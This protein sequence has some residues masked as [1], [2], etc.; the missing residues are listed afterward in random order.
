MWIMQNINSSSLCLNLAHAFHEYEPGSF[1]SVV[2]R[3]YTEN[4]VSI[5]GRG[6]HIFLFTATFR[7]AVPLIQPVF[8]NE[9][10]RLFPLV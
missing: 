3:R 10:R 9:Y 8:F 6:G 4:L 5:L 2:T 7:N 1:G